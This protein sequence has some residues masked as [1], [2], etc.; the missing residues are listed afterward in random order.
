M[1]VNSEASALLSMAG[2]DIELLR[3]IVS[4]EQTTSVQACRLNHAST[5][6]TGCAPVSRSTT[7]PFRS[8]MIAGMPLTPKREA[9]AGLSWVL[10]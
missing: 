6:S 2:K 5:A 7:F 8:N 9:S 10:I 4:S 1:N 3:F